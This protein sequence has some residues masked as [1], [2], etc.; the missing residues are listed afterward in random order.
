[1]IDVGDGVLILL[2]LVC[3]E[4]VADAAILQAAASGSSSDGAA[5]G[6]ARWWAV[7]EPRAGNIQ[8]AALEQLAP[9]VAAI[10]AH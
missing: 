7:F 6:T 5:A 4:L 3:P 10:E 9:A 8:L 2:L 1:V